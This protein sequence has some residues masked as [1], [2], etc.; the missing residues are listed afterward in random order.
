MLALASTLGVREA[1]RNRRIVEGALD[2]RGRILA[3]LEEAPA[4]LVLD[5]CEHVIDGAARWAAD[6]LGSLPGLRIV[7]TSR[8]PLTIGAEQ[9]FPLEPLA[10]MARPAVELFVER[11]S[12]ARPGVDLPIDVIARL[13]TRSTACRSRSSSPPPGCAR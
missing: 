5:N 3:R 7:A 12:A 6:L 1:S 10:S 13:C 4:L 2:V 11:A 9:V 8:S